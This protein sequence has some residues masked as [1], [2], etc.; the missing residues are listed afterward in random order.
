MLFFVHLVN[1]S[2][3][4]QLARCLSTEQVRLCRI[5]VRR[6]TWGCCFTA[7]TCRVYV[8]VHH[9]AC[10]WSDVLLTRIAWC[11]EDVVTAYTYLRPSMCHV[12]REQTRHKVSQQPT[13]MTFRCVTYTIIII[14]TYSVYCVVLNEKLC[15]F[16]FFFYFYVCWDC[17]S[18][19]ICTLFH[20]LAC[21][22]SLQ[23]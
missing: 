13:E 5:Q 20:H 6:R 22:N 11:N 21:L 3:Y 12:C 7:Y 23:R 16:L 4:L 2:N 10:L 19:L 15:L 17:L 18:G 9:R 1:C 8:Y 14:P